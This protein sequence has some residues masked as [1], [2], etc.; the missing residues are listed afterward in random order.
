MFK[1]S[2]KFQN[3]IFLTSL[4]SCFIFNFYFF[5]LFFLLQFKFC[6]ESLFNKM[7]FYF[8]LSVHCHLLRFLRNLRFKCFIGLRTCQ[9]LFHLIL[10][11]W[12][13]YQ[14]ILLIWVFFSSRT[15]I[16]IISFL[17]LKKTLRFFIN[18]RSNIH[19]W[20]FFLQN[21]LFSIILFLLF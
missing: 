9:S 5:I 3:D 11:H 21:S 17:F 16:L 13:L 1:L 4:I 19:N 8:L 18:Y 12:I 20:L 6:F 15:I 10:G 2:I 14:L 7:I